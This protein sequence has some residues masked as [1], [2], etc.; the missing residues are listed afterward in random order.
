MKNSSKSLEQSHRAE[1]QLAR[2]KKAKTEAISEIITA[3]VSEIEI[4]PASTIPSVEKVA[5]LPVEAAKPVEI[6]DEV[7]SAANRK[8]MAKL[9]R[10]FR[11]AGKPEA[12]EAE[13]S[14]FLAS[15]LETKVPVLNRSSGRISRVL[16][17]EQN[18][19]SLLLARDPTKSG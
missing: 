8:M 11:K 7:S 9:S 5:F 13:I 14:A 19:E 18:I 3:P 10:A 4:D 17:G 16:K 12:S 1:A 15:L 2:C 6:A